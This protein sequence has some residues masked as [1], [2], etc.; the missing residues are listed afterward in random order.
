M[1]GY[2][3]SSRL[4]LGTKVW[5]KSHGLG[6]VTRY[7]TS[8]STKEWGEDRL[9]FDPVKYPYVVTFKNGYEDFYSRDELRIDE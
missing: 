2:S 1:V 8:T 5:V 6:V 7:N 4:D 3:P 9:F